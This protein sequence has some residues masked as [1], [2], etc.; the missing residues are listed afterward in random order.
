MNTLTDVRRATSAEIYKLKHSSIIVTVVVLPLVIVALMNLFLP[1]IP[2]N[3]H[4]FDRLGVNPWL[5][6]TVGLLQVWSFIQA[7]IVAVVTAQLAGLEHNNNTWKHLF[8]LPVSRR[9]VYLTKIIVSLGV[10]GLPMLLIFTAQIVTGLLL[11][12]IKP[13]MNFGSAIPWGDMIA[14]LLINYAASWLMITLHAWAANFWHNFGPAVGLALVAFLLNMVMATNANFL[15]IFPWSLP[16]N[17]IVT[18]FNLS[19]NLIN[20]NIAASSVALSITAAAVVAFVA[21][22]QLSRRDVI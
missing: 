10:F 15:R 18:S 8:A 1:L 5:A 16:T 4:P 21:T 13:E 22:W 12:A 7:F 20:G 2:G 11:G 9:A 19:G 14:V 17:F 6:S 3:G